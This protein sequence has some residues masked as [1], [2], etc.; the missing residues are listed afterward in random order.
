MKVPKTLWAGVVLTVAYLINC[1][2]SSVL[3]GVI[4]HSILFPSHSLFP[5]PPK[6]FGCTCFMYDVRPQVTKLDPKSLKCVSLG[7]SRTQKGY[8]CF[9][10]DLNHYLVSSYVSFF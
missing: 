7:Y 2:S 6:I 1:M 9:S 8:R 4:P 5:L 3:N 10:P